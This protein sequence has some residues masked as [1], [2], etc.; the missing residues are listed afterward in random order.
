MDKLKTILIIIAVIV[1]GL[2][3]LSL[4][5]IIY[6]ILSSVAIIA[7]V[8]LAGYVG[9]RVL[10]RSQTAPEREQLRAPDPKKELQKVQRLLEEYK[11]KPD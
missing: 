1:G 2:G 3:V 7:L 8:G 10:T 6:S 4:V 11:R 5:G 9:F